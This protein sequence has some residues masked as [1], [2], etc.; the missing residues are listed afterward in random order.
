MTGH[1]SVDSYAFYDSIDELKQDLKQ[2]KAQFKGKDIPEWAQKR[3]KFLED[4]IK[5]LSH[6]SQGSPF[7]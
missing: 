3:I 7:V 6:L 5:G 2:T 4:G 1:P